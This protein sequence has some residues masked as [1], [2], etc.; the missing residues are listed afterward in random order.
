M[1]CC[2]KHKKWSANGF[3]IFVILCQ[4]AIWFFKMAPSLNKFCWMIIWILLRH[5]CHFGAPERARK[6]VCVTPLQYSLTSVTPPIQYASRH[7]LCYRSLC[8]NL[9]MRPDPCGKSSA[10]RT[11]DKYKFLL[12]LSMSKSSEIPLYLPFFW[13][14]FDGGL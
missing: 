1:R 10:V 11:G 12:C 5:A 3:Y 2:F 14:L 13:L 9:L 6:S 7:I 8:L 4:R